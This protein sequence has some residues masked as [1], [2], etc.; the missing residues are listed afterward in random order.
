M[1]HIRVLRLIAAVENHQAR[2]A[3][4]GEKLLEVSRQILHRRRIDRTAIEWRADGFDVNTL[5][6]QL[7]F[8]TD[9]N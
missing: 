8:T 1:R 4:S 6:R 9:D 5:E 7:K 3:A 2:R